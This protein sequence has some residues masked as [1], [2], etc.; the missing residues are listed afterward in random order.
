M[1]ELKIGD[2]LKLVEIN[3]YQYDYFGHY[4]GDIGTII[5]FFKG[6]PIVFVRN[7]KST[8]SFKHINGVVWDKFVKYKLDVVEI[9]KRK[10]NKLQ[11]GK[12]FR[13]KN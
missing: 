10:L 7:R 13:K 6:Q 2:K 9:R 5:D 8:S 3:Y 4:I 1:Q 12:S 11:N